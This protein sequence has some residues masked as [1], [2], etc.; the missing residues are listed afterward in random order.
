MKRTTRHAVRGITLTELL[1]ALAV[2]GV[3]FLVGGK[4]LASVV[5]PNG[6]WAACRDTATLMT[7]ARAHAAFTGHT[8]GLKMVEAGGDVTVWM[9]EDLNGNGVLT[10][11]I[12]SGEDRLVAGPISLRAGHPG[13]SFSFVPRFVGT[14][15]A[16]NPIGNLSDPV[17][18]GRGDICSFSPLGD[19]S[20]GTIYLSD[21]KSRQAAVRVTPMTAGISVFEVLPGTTTWARKG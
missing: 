11:D 19:A 7:K 15:P 13:V 14:D 1:A 5:G 8:V 10:E 12:R 6:L 17:R 9:Y 21:A 4:C 18:F 2:L 16:G 3:L 20:P